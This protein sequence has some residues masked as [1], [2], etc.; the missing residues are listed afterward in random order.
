[1]HFRF[2]LLSGKKDVVRPIYLARSGE[3][4]TTAVPPPEKEKADV[5]HRER[6]NEC[7]WL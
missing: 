4:L 1:M 2:Y 3:G 5:V 6:K 7:L